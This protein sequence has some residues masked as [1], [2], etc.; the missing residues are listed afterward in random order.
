MSD[1]PASLRCLV[2]IE[3]TK[4]LKGRQVQIQELLEQGEAL[5]ERGKLKEAESVYRRAIDIGP[6]HAGLWVRLG[7]VLEG[8]HRYAEAEE[9]YQKV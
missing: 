9:A 6:Q 4:E 7:I 8:L 2:E 5:E 3:K 1:T